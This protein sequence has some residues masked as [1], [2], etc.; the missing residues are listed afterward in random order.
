[1]LKHL[2]SRSINVYYNKLYYLIIT[3]CLVQF[4]CKQKQF[5][6][7]CELSGRNATKLLE[8]IGEPDER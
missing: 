1:M 5:V 6:L 4:T 2:K 8:M 3:L 7:I